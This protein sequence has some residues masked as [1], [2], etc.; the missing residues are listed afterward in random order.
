MDGAEELQDHDRVPGGREGQRPLPRAGGPGY[1]SHDHNGAR[2]R[3]EPQD[4]D[5][6]QD[7]P[8]GQRIGGLQQGERQG[9][10]GSPGHPPDRVARKQAGLVAQDGR[11]VPVWVEIGGEHGSVRYVAVDVQAQDWRAHGDRQTPDGDDDPGLAER[12]RPPAGQQAQLQPGDD[13]ERNPNDH[14]GGQC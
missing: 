6:S 13:D 10:I 12:D 9:A 4:E 2:E 5:R 11:A 8:A 7:A 3:D 1:A 14:K